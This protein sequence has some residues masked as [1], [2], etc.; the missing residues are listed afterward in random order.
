MT[1]AEWLGAAEV[2]HIALEPW[3]MECDCPDGQYRA[4]YA[5]TPAGCSCKHS[6]ALKAALAAIG[7][8]R[9]VPAA[10]PFEAL[11]RIA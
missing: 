10:E 5:P 6:V 4:H 3:G 1:E 7:R 2:Y 8:L 9:E 11:A